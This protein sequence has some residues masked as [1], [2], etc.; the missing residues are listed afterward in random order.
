MQEKKER[1]GVES[2]ER[3]AGR[4]RRRRRREQGRDGG[5]RRV[6]GITTVKF[7]DA[8]TMKGVATDLIEPGHLLC[9]SKFLLVLQT[10]LAI[11]FT[12]VQ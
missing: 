4:R 3:M 2:S 12:V 10:C 11:I 5:S 1:D 6:G 7:F 8:F 9:S